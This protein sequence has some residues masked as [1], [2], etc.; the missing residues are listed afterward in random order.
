M[1]LTHFI[2][3]ANDRLILIASGTLIKKKKR[4]AIWS[5]F[6]KDHTC[7]SIS[8]IKLNEYVLKPQFV[9]LE[10]RVCILKNIIDIVSL[11]ASYLGNKASFRVS[12]S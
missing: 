8:F 9:N 1:S 3:N 6:W 10:H 2:K 5:S 12:N 7:Q 4:K 11:A